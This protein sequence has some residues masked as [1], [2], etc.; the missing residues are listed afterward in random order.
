MQNMHKKS[1]PLVRVYETLCAVQIVHYLLYC[2]GYTAYC[3]PRLIKGQLRHDCTMALCANDTAMLDLEPDTGG[4]PLKVLQLKLVSALHA[5]TNMDHF[6]SNYSWKGATCSVLHAKQSR[7]K[8]RQRHLVSPLPD[9]CERW[10]CHLH[11]ATVPFQRAF[12]LFIY[13]LTACVVAAYWRVKF[14]PGSQ[15]DF[16]LGNRTFLCNGLL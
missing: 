11:D 2:R 12:F 9:W 15:A 8:W 14:G 10:K 3:S 13:F 7:T 1:R 16:Q 5:R 4:F 6:S